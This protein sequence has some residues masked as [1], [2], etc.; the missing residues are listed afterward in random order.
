MCMRMRVSN[1]PTNNQSTNQIIMIMILILIP[2]RMLDVGNTGLITKTQMR[3]AEKVLG[4]IVDNKEGTEGE[5]ADNGELIDFEHFLGSIL[6]QME[7]PHWINSASREVS[8]N[9]HLLFFLSSFIA[10]TLICSH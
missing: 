10:S 3:L 8:V 4:L 1:S 9:F 6:E 2:I 5:D 7:K